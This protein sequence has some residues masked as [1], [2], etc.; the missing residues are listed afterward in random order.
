MNEEIKVTNTPT[1]ESLRHQLQIEWQDHIQTRQQ[2]WESLKIEAV[3]VVGLIG[4][5]LKFSNIY[6]VIIIGI[7]LFFSSL[8]GLAIT[9]HHRKGQIRKFIHID[10]IEERLHLHIPGLL[11]DVF[12]PKPFKWIDI[13]NPCKVNTPLFILRIHIAI[14]LFTV[15]Y[16]IARFYL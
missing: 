15:V 7:I 1:D 8:S 16:I 14:L 12:P 2:T 4:A 6:I 10:R 11:D 9:I 5:D 13:I 3:L